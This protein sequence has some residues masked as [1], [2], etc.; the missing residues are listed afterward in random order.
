MK[1]S[2]TPAERRSYELLID[3]QVRVGCRVVCLL[4]IVLFPFF[5][6]LDYF[7]QSHKLEEL[8][9]IRYWVV[10]IYILLYGYIHFRYKTFNPTFIS[11]IMCCGASLAITIQ[12]NILGGFVSPYYSGVIL[13]MVT[14]V[15]ALSYPAQKIAVFVAFEIAIYFFGCLYHSGFVLTQPQAVLNNMFSIVATGLIGVTASYWGEEMRRLAFDRYLQIEKT[16]RDLKS[17]QELLQQELKTEQGNVEILVKEI[18]QRKSELERALNLRKEF[19]SLASHELNTPLTSL[20][21]I[22]QMVKL[23][24]SKG[25]SLDTSIIN[26]LLETYDQQVKRLTRIV[27]DMLDISKMESGKLELEKNLVDLDKLIK[28]VVDFSSSGSPCP[29][30]YKSNGPVW[31]EMDGF[32]IEQVVLNLITNAIKYGQ[33]NPVEI[34][35]SKEHGEAIITVKDQGIGIPED[36]RDR[37]FNRFER[38]VTSYQFQGLGLGLYIAKEIVQGHDGT[39]EVHSEPGRGSEFKVHLPLHPEARA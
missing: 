13:V 33:S 11:F 16:K 34:R 8:W 21:L 4:A 5:G 39:I 12:C 18:T 37:I 6:I 3:E 32:R 36:S 10:S 7:T 26:R 30:T 15:V 19:I 1:L 22:T 27:G 24:L 31:G 28:D 35:L 25:G 9:N 17:S 2:W 38:A 29:I 14:T 20:K 23:R